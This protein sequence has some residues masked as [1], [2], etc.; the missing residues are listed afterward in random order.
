MRKLILQIQM[1]VDGFIADALGKS[2]WMIWNWGSDWKWDAALQQY[3]HDI[4]SSVDCVLLS[5]KMAEEGFIHHWA[6]VALQQNNPQSGFAAAIAKTRK[7]IFTRTLEQSV[8]PNATLAKGDLAKE[9][10]QLKTAPGKNIIA[11]GGAS[12]AASLVQADLVDEFHLIINPALLGSGLSV[13]HSIR[14]IYSLSLI[15]SV[16]YPCGVVVTTYS[17]KR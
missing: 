9:V 11:Y 17:R 5:R 1:S 2:G 12:F 13:F 6:S 16:A 10:Y 15:N 3:H 4:S 8:W 14:D 7:V